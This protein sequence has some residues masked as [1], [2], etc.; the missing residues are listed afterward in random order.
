[1]CAADADSNSLTVGEMVEVANDRGSFVARL[2]VGRGARPVSPSRP[3]AAGP[4]PSPA[5]DSVNATVAERDSDMGAGAVYHDN[6]VTITPITAVVPLPALELH[7]AAVDERLHALV[8]V[9]GA[10]GQLLRPRLVLERRLC[11]RCRAIG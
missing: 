4:R 6:R 11:G 8:E 2:A 3:R 7:L 1:M 10:A 5:A 9:V